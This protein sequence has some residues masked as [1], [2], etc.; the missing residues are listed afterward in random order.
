[1]WV[2][3]QTQFELVENGVKT[4]PIAWPTAKPI[5][6]MALGAKGEKTLPIA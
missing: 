2:H 1:V 5:E 3:N 4:P 6:Q